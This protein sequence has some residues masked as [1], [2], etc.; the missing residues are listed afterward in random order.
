MSSWDDKEIIISIYAGA[1]AG[2][3][4]ACTRLSV[5]WGPIPHISAPLA[6]GIDLG[7]SQ[8][9]IDGA[10]I[11]ANRKI[12]QMLEFPK[13]LLGISLGAAGEMYE[14]IGPSFAGDGVGR[15]PKHRRVMTTFCEVASVH[16]GLNISISHLPRM[17]I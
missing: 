6:Q 11:Q 2:D 12:M 5:R 16:S 15:N 3:V 10:P 8:N 4:T 9:T 14:S 1:C 17:T 13:H 7:T